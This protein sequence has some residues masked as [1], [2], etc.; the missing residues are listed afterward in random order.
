MSPQ[1]CGLFCCCCGVVPDCCCCCC[2]GV[3]PCCGCCCPWV[4]CCWPCCCCCGCLPP[5]AP[6]IWPTV[7]CFCAGCPLVPGCLFP[8]TPPRMLP[9]A[10]GFDSVG[11]RLSSF[12]CAIF[13]RSGAKC[14]F[15]NDPVTIT[16]MTSSPFLLESAVCK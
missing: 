8:I 10:P 4:G 15:W 6:R 16:G 14:G 2:C 9:N 7:S 3:C 13:C 11:T 12:I 1:L 5:S